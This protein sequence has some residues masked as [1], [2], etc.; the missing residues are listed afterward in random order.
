ME[1]GVSK[2]ISSSGIESLFTAQKGGLI[3]AQSGMYISGT[4]TGDKYPALLEN[5]EYV[6]NRNAVMA[7]GGPA[8]L[9]TLNFSAAPRFASGGSFN[10][11]LGDIKAMEENMTTFGLE[12]SSYYKELRDE[13]VRKAEEARQK[14]RARDAHIAQIVGSL[15]ASVATAGVS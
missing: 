3:R 11:E 5:G 2:L 6:L 7:M 13:E 12:N 8:A 1:V 14:K 10:T 9:D 15:V 4:G